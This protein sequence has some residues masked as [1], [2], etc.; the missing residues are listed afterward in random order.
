MHRHSTGSK[1]VS[2]ICNMKVFNYQVLSLSYRF[3]ILFLPSS[4]CW[5]GSFLPPL[6]E[7]KRNPFV[8]LSARP[9]PNIQ[10]RKCRA[11]KRR[12]LTGTLPH[13]HPWADKTRIHSPSG[14]QSRES[15]SGGIFHTWCLGLSSVGSASGR[16]KPW[17]VCSIYAALPP[18]PPPSSL[19]DST[20]QY[21]LL[22][23]IYLIL[24]V[25]Y[26]KNVFLNQCTQQQGVG[27]WG[28][29]RSHLGRGTAGEKKAVKMKKKNHD[30][31][32]S[33][34]LLF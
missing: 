34:E 30:G 15:D 21:G 14:G 10:F 24:Q 22:C 1:V 12:E 19:A 27:G 3:C 29:G 5:C 2:S 6:K 16:Q 13:I 32:S 31:S 26:F 9:I 7:L 4:F 28:W 11:S 20:L 8:T 17:R 23:Q 25:L 33:P 18:L